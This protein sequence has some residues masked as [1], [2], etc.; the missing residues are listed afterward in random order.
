MRLSILASFLFF[1]FFTQAGHIRGGEIQ[2]QCLGGGGYQFQL[3]LFVDCFGAGISGAQNIQGPFGAIYCTLD[4]AASTSFNTNCNS[5][6]L[7]DRWVFK[8]DTVTLTGIPPANGWEFSWGACCRDEEQNLSANTGIFLR[9]RMYSYQPPG[10]A[11]PLS[12]DSCFNHSPNFLNKDAPVHCDGSFSYNHQLMDLDQDSISVEFTDPYSFSSTAVTFSSGYDAQHPFPDSTENPLNG[13][14][15]LN[16]QTGLMQATFYGASPGMYYHALWVKEYRY[17]QLISERVR[18]MPLIVLDSTTCNPSYTNLAPNLSLS[19]NNN[20]VLNQQ[21]SVYHINARLGDTVDLDLLATDF[22]F[23]ANG[24]P[25]TICLKSRSNYINSA[26]P[27]LNTGCLAGNCATVNP[28]GSTGFCGSVAE[29]YHFQWAP[30][31]A[32][33][34][35]TGTGPVAHLFHFEVVDNACPI[36]KAKAITIAVNLLPATQNPTQISLQ[37][38]DTMGTVELSWARATLPGQVPFAMYRV[39]M[40]PLGGGAFTQIDSIYDIDSLSAR[41][42]GLPFPAEIYVDIVSGSCLG[43]S[44]HS[45]VINTQ[46]IL[47]QSEWGLLPERFA[48]YPNPAHDKVFI[49]ALDQSVDLTRP[50]AKLLAPDGRLLK[51]YLLPPGQ[52]DWEITLPKL[53]GL[54]LVEVAQQ[55][56]PLLI[57]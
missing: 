1:S 30:D 42:T 3:T 20:L 53:K 4:S 39:F 32:G 2:W 21:G 25:Q 22:D 41:Y 5:I 28:I 54:Y 16:P 10:A 57:K 15:S 29:S 11:T 31:C 51:T 45:N 40:R 24:A 49:K 43:A 23:N 6:C 52:A 19:S 56:Y 26:N 33:F 46:A 50:E 7:Q 55:T 38:A 8:S 12:A 47:S 44:L 14:T 17:G 36:S 35:P 27:T 48:L 18:D 34:R 37:A 9:A 13:A